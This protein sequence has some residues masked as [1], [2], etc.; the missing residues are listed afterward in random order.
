MKF[1]HYILLDPNTCNATK[2]AWVPNGSLR[3]RASVE[4][5]PVRLFCSLPKGHE[6]AHCCSHDLGGVPEERMWPQ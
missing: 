4:Y 2:E 3:Q 5:I 1:S 6:G